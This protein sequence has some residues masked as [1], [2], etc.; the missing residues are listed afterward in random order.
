MEGPTLV[1]TPA[2]ATPSAAVG[3]IAGHLSYP[4]SALPLDLRVCAVDQVTSEEHCTAERAFDAS[5][6][7]FAYELQLDPG[8]YLVYA[9]ATGVRAYY[10]EFVRCGLKPS[11]PSH[12]PVVVTVSSGATTDGVDPGDWYVPR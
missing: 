12:E 1:S 6:K 7:Q 5:A 11:C 4:G 9:T 2:T 8:A 10:S 3:A